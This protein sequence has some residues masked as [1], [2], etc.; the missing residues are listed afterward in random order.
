MKKRL[1]YF[2]ATLLTLLFLNFIVTPHT[3]AETYHSDFCN[4]LGTWKNLI[5]QAD[6]S[7]S[8]GQFV[9][10]NQKEGEHYENVSLITGAGERSSGDLQVTFAYKG[11]K[12]FGLIFRASESSPKNYQAFVYLGNGNW[13][14]SQSTPK[15]T[16]DIK[17]PNLTSEQT[18]KLLLRYQGSS[19]QAYLNE[20]LIYD[21]PHVSYREG[22]TIA[23]DWKGYIGLGFFNPPS[24]LTVLSIKSGDIG[25]ISVDVDPHEFVKLRNKWK[26]QL[27]TENYNPNIPSLVKYVK[28]LSDNAKVLYQS[29]S[30]NPQRT[31]LWSLQPGESASAHLTREVTN[32]YYL[33][34]AYGTQGTDY[35]QDPKLLAAIQSGF[36]FIVSQKGYDGNK[37]YGNWWDWQIGIPQKFIGSLMILGDKISEESLQRY[38]QALSAYVPNPYQQLYTKPQE[39]FVDLSF[40][41]N[42]STTGANRTDL[43]LS[44]LGLG[45]LQ[46]DENK[47]ECASNSIKEV[48]QLVSQGD[49]FYSDGSF[50]QHNKIPYTGAYGNVLINGIG[51]ILALTQ[52]SPFEMDNQSVSN[53]VNIVESSFLPLIYQGTMLPSVNGRSISRAPKDDQMGCSTMYNLLTVAALAPVDVQKKL[54]EAVKY[55]IQEN[56]DYYLNN[57]RNYNSLQLVLS[58]L[59]DN[60]ISGQKPPF[61][62]TKNF[63]SMDRFVQSTPNYLLNLSL[64]SNRIYSFEAGNGENKHGWHTGDGMLYLYNNDGVQFG[65]SYW[66]TV[67]PYRL[68]GTTVDTVA[69]Q[70]EASYFTTITSLETWVG[71]VASENQAVMGMSLNK[72]GTKNNGILL[73]MNLRAKKSWFIL[74]NQ[75]IALGA[76]ISGDTTADIETIVDNRLLNTTY[77]YQ[78]LSSTGLINTRSEK[79]KMDWLLLQS[80]QQ[81]VSIGYIF[82]TAQEIRLQSEKR[83]GTYAAINTAF[84]SD[85]TYTGD[86]WKF[87]I[88][89]GKNPINASY[90]YVI[91]PGATP[92]IL[93]NYNKNKDLKILSNT[94]SIQAVQM[95]KVG[96]LGI[97]FWE[98]SGGTIAGITSDKPISFMKQTKAKEILYTISD[99]TQSNETV[100]IHLPQT[101]Q[102]ILS[103]SEG[104]SFD[105]VTH[106]FIVDFSGSAGQAKQIV[107]GSY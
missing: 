12:N 67:D 73:P 106:S 9:M 21:E 39:I 53:F 30:L 75:T 79:E 101:S 61:I 74:D 26:E 51:Q 65:S 88:N 81:K 18:Y 10:S 69:L 85:T 50:I 22:S 89:H 15:Q 78:L 3:L 14:L 8:H 34:K 97:N 52:G 54:Q 56:P 7:I 57:P 36:D 41:P 66:P 44:V 2:T 105:E 19:I 48:F 70:D 96:Y 59:A 42:F 83:T 49:G 90:A 95:D 80:N 94:A 24:Q 16:I 43:A 23:G 55:W 92:D 72:E 31:S 6:R 45:I 91:F 100:H 99:P 17:G 38:T 20:K 1:L 102:N 98:S 87:I 4:H 32:L 64:Y 71:G 27:V 63:S 68:P 84:P 37:Y 93:K 33:S 28:S 5:G 35:F 77:H 103:M 58:L 104:I 11:Q 107:L 40:V 46:K 13:Q 25:S 82:P 62:G 86:Y 60:T 47:I 76:G 29:M